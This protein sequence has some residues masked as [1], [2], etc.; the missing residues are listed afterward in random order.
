MKDYYLKLEEKFLTYQELSKA[1]I[2]DNLEKLISLS[3]L[4]IQNFSIDERMQKYTGDEIYVRTGVAARLLDVQEYLNEI[5]P[6][7]KL[8]VV[9]GYRHPVI[10]KQ[11]YEDIKRRI[12]KAQPDGWT[13]IALKEKIHHFIAVPE[14][15]G[16]PTG[17]AVDVR[18]I[19][20]DGEELPM[21]TQ[22]HDFVSDSYVFSPFISKEA[23]NNRQ[24]LRQA[25]MSAGFA[26]FDGEWWHFSYGDRE[27][28]IF[29][30]RPEAVYDQIEFEL[31]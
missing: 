26:P 30:N 21:G 28:S 25:M 29:Y 3:G 27:W 31:S 9:Y 13:E 6:G 10:Q 14:V 7:T 11:S 23:W 4:N 19:G 16:H 8:E 1:S 20:A 17:G 24:K 12:L 22:V 2:K 5:L 18:L 15:A